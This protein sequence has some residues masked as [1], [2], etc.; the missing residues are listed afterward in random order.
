ML[1]S[2]ITA[3][4]DRDNPGVRSVG[5]ERAVNVKLEVIKQLNTVQSLSWNS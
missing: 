5:F 4:D 2:R 3:D 1:A